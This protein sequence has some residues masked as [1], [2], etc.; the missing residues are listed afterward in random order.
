MD[1]Y[2]RETLS[3]LPLA[4]SVM[5]L[6]QYALD[7]EQLAAVFDRHRGRSYGKV[8]SFEQIVHLVADALLEHGGSAR[9]S[10]KRAMEM[11][12]LPVSQQAVYGKLR[13]MP[14]SLSNGFLLDTTQRLQELVSP[15][16]S[17]IPKSLRKFK[18]IAIDG[19]KIKHVWKRLKVTRKVKGAVLGG[20]TL[21]ALCVERGLA[22]AMSAHLDGEVSDAPLM[23]DLL[24]QLD[25]SVPGTW[26]LILDRQFSDLVQPTQIT[27]QGHHFLIRHNKKLKFHR[28]HGRA[29]SRGVDQNGR[30]YVEEWGWIGGPT[31]K[32]R[33]YVRCITLLRP[34]DEDVALLTDLVDADE[35]P[36]T[37][38]L[39]AYLARW[40]IER[41]FQ[42]ITDV[43]HL[44]N[45]ISSAPGGMIFQFAFCLVLYNMIELLRN[46]FARQQRIARETI[47]T[48]NLFQ[49]VHRQLIAWRELIGPT[50]TIECLRPI[51]SPQET[52][53]RLHELLAPT[54]TD[55][56]LKEPKK[57][58]QPPP[59]KT[60][61]IP[62]A[63]TS[64][65]RLMFPPPKPR[66]P[67]KRRPP[68]TVSRK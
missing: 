49:D 56:W 51:A 19:K 34:G 25:R 12:A 43:F 67:R 10:M 6:W 63:H 5:R 3:R 35:Y 4:E 53:K 59:K 14:I 37:D 45:L 41:V 16:R 20:K 60:T 21:T 64:V 11:E 36:A 7:D 68:L 33:R 31:D 50:L 23:P 32:R 18:L 62:G 8:L 66:K 52:R 38:L 57:K 27:A 54:W 28:D 17:T 24:D 22:L 58:H 30:K 61:E 65:F 42:R 29:M 40:G 9:Q 44:R 55:R 39:D 2:T 47:S 46:E 48:E 1:G 13:R 15:T 26:L